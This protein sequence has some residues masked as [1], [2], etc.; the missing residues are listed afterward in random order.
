MAHLLRLLRERG[1]SGVNS[2]ERIKDLYMVQM[3]VI[4]FRL[5]RKGFN[6]ISEK[7]SDQSVNYILI[8]K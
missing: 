7:Q 6:I 1:E 5:K 3:P 2:F 8:E 4:I